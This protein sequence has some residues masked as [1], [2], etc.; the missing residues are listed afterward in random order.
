[1]RKSIY[2]SIYTCA[3]C[4]DNKAESRTLISSF[5]AISVLQ[6]TA[7]QL[8]IEYLLCSFM[9]DLFQNDEVSATEGQFFRGLQY[10]TMQFSDV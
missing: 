7:N 10:D 5:A 2:L 1:M 4:K 6:M 3:M 8:E 9:I